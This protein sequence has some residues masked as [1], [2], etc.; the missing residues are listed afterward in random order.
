MFCLLMFP[1]IPQ[2]VVLT[3]VDEACPMVKEDLRNIY[4]SIYMKSMVRTVLSDTY[5]RVVFICW[6]I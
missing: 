5:S 6:K 2:L 1:G 4:R 3:K